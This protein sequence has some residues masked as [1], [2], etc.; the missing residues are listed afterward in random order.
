MQEKMVPKFASC[1]ERS[2]A[3]PTRIVPTC[4]HKTVL[5]F[6]SHEQAGFMQALSLTIRQSA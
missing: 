1:P 2:N 3:S 4:V 5:V 6:V